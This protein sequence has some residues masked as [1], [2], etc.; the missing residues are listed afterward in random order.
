[1]NSYVVFENLKR[2]CPIYG[3]KVLAKDF[4][5]SF[6]LNEETD[7]YEEV[8]LCRKCRDAGY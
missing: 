6:R 8:E 7:E 4:I 1:M 3:E 2:P 5:H